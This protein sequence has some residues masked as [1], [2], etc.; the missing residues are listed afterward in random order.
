[1]NILIKLLA[2]TREVGCSGVLMNR[3]RHL[4][5]LCDGDSDGS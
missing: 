3:D 4:E 1:M 5:T 2:K